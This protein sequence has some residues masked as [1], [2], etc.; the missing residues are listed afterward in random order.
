[1]GRKPQ[2]WCLGNCDQTILAE[3]NRVSTRPVV[4]VLSVAYVSVLAMMLLR[5]A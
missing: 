3:G 5:P 1:L 4:L 2:S